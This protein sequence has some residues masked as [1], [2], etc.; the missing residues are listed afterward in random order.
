MPIISY[1]GRLR[2]DNSQKNQPYPIS[3]RFSETVPDPDFENR[4]ILRKYILTFYQ[5]DIRIIRY[6]SENATMGKKTD[7]A[8]AES[9]WL[10]KTGSV[11]SVDNW[12]RSS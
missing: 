10:V 11:V 12:P 1:P 3:V 6:I 9:R 2:N 4:R 7:P 5:E 8:L